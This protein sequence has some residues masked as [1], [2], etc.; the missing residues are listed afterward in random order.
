MDESEKRRERLR[1][2][3][4]EAAQAEVS[5]G[6]RSHAV[7]GALSNPL[8]EASDV[9]DFRAA[10]RF[11]FYTD[12]M[13]A[14]SSNKWRSNLSNQNPRDFSTPHATGGSP[15]VQFPPSASGPRSSQIIP[16]H[17]HHQQTNYPS[18]QRTY[19]AGPYHSPGPTRSPVPMTS[20]YSVH[21]GTPPGIWNESGAPSYNAVNYS[22]VANSPSPGLGWVSGPSFGSPARGRGQWSTNSSSPGSGR[23]GSS[24]PHSGRGRGRWAGG[25]ASPP[26]RS[27]LG[28]GT[29]S[30]GDGPAR[31]FY[32]KSMLE[33][34]WKSLEPVIW[35]GVNKKWKMSESRTLET[36]H[37]PHN[38]KKT[39]VSEAFDLSNSKQSLADYLAAAFDEAVEDAAAV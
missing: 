18:D 4:M 13:A 7:P 21:Y 29:G 5:N 6:P 31:G 26:S 37:S 20:P 22:R 19:Q 23:G 25:V 10:P 38:M 8:L 33:D 14:F 12:P 30:R 9:Q 36:R 28:R 24:S 17:V 15:M 35:R 39:K 2:L 3:R 34:P 1:A 27:G 32:D 11:D 16:S